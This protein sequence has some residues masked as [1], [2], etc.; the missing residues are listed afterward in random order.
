MRLSA[1]AKAAWTTHYND[2]AVEQADLTGD[3]AAAWSKLEEYA[4]RLALVVHFARWA[5]GDPV[6]NRGDVLDAESMQA[7]IVLVEWVKHEA[8]R[9][10]AIL[11]ESVESPNG[12]LLVEW[13]QRRAREW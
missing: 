10:Y 1:D 11:G 7:G 9:V 8:R 5:A 2:H 12:R 4:A 6:H 13:L 3:M